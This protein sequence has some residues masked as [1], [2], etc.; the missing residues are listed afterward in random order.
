MPFNGPL[1]NREASWEKR[2]QITQSKK[3]ATL[4]EF[5]PPARVY[6]RLITS[7][8]AVR[9]FRR[10]VIATLRE[11]ERGQ[12]KTSFCL[13]T[14][15]FACFVCKERVDRPWA[16]ATI[17]RRQKLSLRART[18]SNV[19]PSVVQGPAF[20]DSFVE[21]S[22]VLGLENFK[23]TTRRSLRVA[24][25]LRSSVRTDG[26]TARQHTSTHTCAR[27]R[28]LIETRHGLRRRQLPDRHRPEC[29]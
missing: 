23:V 27:R 17:R 1:S 11:R 29:C 7:A 8:Y 28:R 16:T 20:V 6:Y 9:I 26:R 13:S 3:I 18:S 24:S 4:R 14:K 21:R 2:K 15:R 22:F 12:V 10:R 19:R 5:I 25:L